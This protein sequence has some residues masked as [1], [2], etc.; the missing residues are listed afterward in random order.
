MQVG[1][2][3]VIRGPATVQLTQIS[4]NMVFSKSQNARQVG[5]LCIEKTEHFSVISYFE[6]IEPSLIQSQNFKLFSSFRQSLF[7]FFLS[8]VWLIYNFVRFCEFIFQT[9]AKFF[10]F[11]SWKLKRFI[12]K[13]IFFRILSI[14]KQKSF[15]YRPNFQWRFWFLTLKELIHLWSNPQNLRNYLCWHGWPSKSILWWGVPASETSEKNKKF[16]L[17]KVHIFWEGHKILRNIPLTF[18]RST[19]SQKLGED[20]AKFCGPL[21]IYKL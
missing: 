21:R 11:L 14:S 17:D 2:F 18:D 20:F 13:R 5:P 9:D 12:P 1:D 15:V 8:V 10:S 7:S 3:C 6:V 16:V 19:Y 4:C